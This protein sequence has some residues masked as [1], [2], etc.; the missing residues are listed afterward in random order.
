MPSMQEGMLQVS[1][2]AGNPSAQGRD[3]VLCSLR[4]E[5]MSSVRTAVTLTPRQ[6]LQI[7]GFYIKQSVATIPPL[8]DF[9]LSVDVKHTAISPRGRGEGLNTSYIEKSGPVSVSTMLLTLLFCLWYNAVHERKFCGRIGR[10][11]N[12]QQ[13][14]CPHQFCSLTSPPEGGDF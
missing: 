1:M 6:S 9:V 3:V 4:L 12:F 2:R 10:K 13:K 8:E 14:R 7:R 11:Y 5:E